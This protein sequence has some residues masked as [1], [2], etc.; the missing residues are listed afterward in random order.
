MISKCLS[1]VYYTH[2]LGSQVSACMAEAVSV[3]DPVSTT[4]GSE[5]AAAAANGRNQGAILVLG[6]PF[7]IHFC[8]SLSLAT[9]SYYSCT[10]ARL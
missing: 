10:A 9:C 5:K 8:L 7:L 3:A 2:T 4:V 6:G 1:G